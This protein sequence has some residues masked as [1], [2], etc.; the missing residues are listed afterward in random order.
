MES[1]GKLS[2]G[3]YMDGVG[4]YATGNTAINDGNWH[5]LIIIN[6]T[7]DNTQKLFIDG[8]NTPDIN[9]TLTSGTKNAQPIQI[10]YYA[11]TGGY[12]W[13]GSIDQVRLYNIA[14]SSS[15]ITAL[16]NETAA[17]PTTSS[18]PSFQTAVETYTMDTS[19]NGLLT[20]TDFLTSGL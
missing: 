10:G 19:A 14:L 5:N 6:N 8:N 3:N 18:F 20:T 4:S 11:T 13:N 2:M 16:Y 15:N 7:S 9:H 12:V 17:T 1:T